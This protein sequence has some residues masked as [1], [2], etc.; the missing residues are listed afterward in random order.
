MAH[1]GAHAD[2]RFANVKQNVFIAAKAATNLT[3]IDAEAEVVIGSLDVGLEPKQFVVSDAV[4][5]VAAIDQ[6]SR[7]IAVVEL[8]SGSLRILDLDF[9]PRG[10]TLA[11]DG[12]KLA[13]VGEHEFVLFDLLFAKQTARATGLPLL[14]TRCSAATARSFFKLRRFGR[15]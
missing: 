7:R 1:G 13:A 2:E 10:L 12:L 4:A 11:P 6:A 8:V 5:K 14:G 3:V 9:T 15:R